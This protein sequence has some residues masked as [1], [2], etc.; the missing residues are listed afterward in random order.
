MTCPQVARLQ[1]QMENN[2]QKDKQKII[3]KGWRT[4]PR[5]LKIVIIVVFLI[6]VGSFF[7]FDWIGKAKN[8]WEIIKPRQEKVK[9]VPAPKQQEQKLPPKEGLQNGSF[10]EGLKYW[11]VMNTITPIIPATGP[12]VVY[13]NI[14]PDAA[15]TYG[16]SNYFI[17]SIAQSGTKSLQVNNNHPEAPHKYFAFWQRISGLK[18]SKKYRISF[19]VMGSVSSLNSLWCAFGNHKTWLV[20]EKSFH[21]D[22]SK[23]YE[24]WQ[25]VSGI[26]QNGNYK[27]ANIYLISSDS[28]SI[29]IDNVALT[30]I[31]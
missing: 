12:T 23:N 8:A 21:I 4:L 3:D 15:T 11:N 18:E 2:F 7:I 6:F 16:E 31:E 22:L 28:C 10:E 5:G 13:S 1:I 17:S 27:E 9:E 14:T 19:Y 25:E 29:M 26:V 24:D 20:E 30:E